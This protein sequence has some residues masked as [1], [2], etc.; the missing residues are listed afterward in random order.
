[1]SIIADGDA[2]SWAHDVARQASTD[3][4]RLR[5]RIAA[6]EAGYSLTTV[7]VATLPIVGS[8][9]PWVVVSDEVGGAI[10][11]YDDGTN[12]RRTSDGAVV[13]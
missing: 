11:A 5:D 7:T 10:A 9:F 12:W 8:G 2:P 13:S 4:D 1:M 3:I 6:L